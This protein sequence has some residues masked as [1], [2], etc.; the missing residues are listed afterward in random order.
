MFAMLA[1]YRPLIMFLKNFLSDRIKLRNRYL[2]D[3]T[4]LFQNK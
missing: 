3:T 2:E 1:R 4:V